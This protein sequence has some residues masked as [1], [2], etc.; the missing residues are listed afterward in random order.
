MPIDTHVI[1]VDDA[2]EHEDCRGCWCQPTVV[3][4]DWVGHG[5]VVVHR[6]ADG[7]ELHEKGRPLPPATR[8]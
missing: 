4:P 1:P 2:I 6:S 5:K 7:R 3:E 8:H